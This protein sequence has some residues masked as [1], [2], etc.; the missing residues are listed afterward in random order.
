LIDLDFQGWLLKSNNSNSIE[1]VIAANDKRV[2][3]NRWLIQ[4]RHA[5]QVDMGII[6]AAVGRSIA[7]KPNILLSVTTGHFTQQ[8]H[9]YVT[10]AMQLTNLQILL[11]DTHDLEALVHDET[12]IGD[13][14]G[15]ETK[16]AKSTKEL[17]MIPSMFSITEA[18]DEYCS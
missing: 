8:A 18:V 11:I 4:C 9:Y 1:V 3:F 15:R 14:L 12:A 7:F 17:Q 16:R 5:R 6:A 13:I 10:R 2:P